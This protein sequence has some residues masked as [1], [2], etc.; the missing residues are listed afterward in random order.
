MES[1]KKIFDLMDEKSQMS[2]YWMPLVWATN[3]INRARKESHIQN[4]HVVQTMLVE[5]SDIRRRLGSLIGYDTVCVPLVVTLSVYTYFVAALMGRQWVS[6]PGSHNS[7]SEA[8]VTTTPT[9][10][11]TLGSSKDLDLFFPVFTVLQFCFYI[12]WL[13]VAEVLINPFGEDDDDIEL[14][15]LIDRH[16]KESVDTPL[17]ERRKNWFQRQLHRMGSVR[18][19]NTTYSSGGLFTGGGARTAPS[20]R[21][22]NAYTNTTIQQ[23]DVNANAAAITTNPQ[24]LSLYDRLMSR[25]SGR[26]QLQRGRHSTSKMN[27][28]GGSSNTVPVA[29]KN[30]PRIPTPD[31]TKESPPVFDIPSVISA[32][33]REAMESSSESNNGVIS[34]KPSIITS[35]ISSQNIGN[36][37]I[38]TTSSGGLFGPSHML[39][40]I[41][42][43]QA[44]ANN[45][46]HGHHSDLPVVQVVL[47]PIKELEHL[48][49]LPHHPHGTAALAQAVLSPALTSAG[50]ATVLPGTAP[51]SAS[52]TPP[53][54]TT[55]AGSIT[56]SSIPF[57]SVVA[58]ALANQAS[59]GAAGSAPILTY[60]PPQHLLPA[61]HTSCTLSSNTSTT[62]SHCSASSMAL[63]LQLISD[64]GGGGV[65]GSSESGLGSEL[66]EV[67]DHGEGEK[68]GE[69]GSRSR[70]SSVASQK[71]HKNKRGEVYLSLVR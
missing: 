24:K 54:P 4:D 22:G 12:G 67:V 15:W 19:A 66:G 62:S 57:G 34:T 53:P 70:K 31:V 28:S 1:E 7:L 59:S 65:G 39:H 18:S 9:P 41:L 21:T 2:K 32:L 64:G 11:E 42:Q 16:L 55:S 8:I 36:N 5:L 58:A 60:L 23:G 29:V 47:S 25:K 13:K 44:A 3:I 40:P 43:Q 14:N 63:P 69:E 56:M 48:P 35:N 46:Y 49:H 50:I 68:E 26:G 27:G 52:S 20:S 10:D 51:P 6:P 30:R 61:T 37:T 45:G 33:A 17:V 71:Q 38:T